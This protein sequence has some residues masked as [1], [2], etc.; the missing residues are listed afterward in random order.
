MLNLS[1]YDIDLWQKGLLMT[2]ENIVNRIEV[3]LTVN[4]VRFVVNYLLNTILLLFFL[5]DKWQL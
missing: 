5:L 1:G 2:L 4:T 3:I